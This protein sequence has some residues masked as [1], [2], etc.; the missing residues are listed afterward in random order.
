M[1]I[2]GQGLSGTWLSYWL[3]QAGISFLVVDDGAPTAA[4]RICSGVI[5]PVTGRRM[6][7]TWLASELLPFAT[8]AYTAIGAFLQVGKPL[9]SGSEILDFFSAPDRRL[10][11]AEKAAAGNEYLHWP[12]DQNQWV[13]H[14]NYALGFGTISPAYLVNVQALLLAWRDWLSHKGL[15]IAAGFHED[16]LVMQE[17]GVEWHDVKARFA[18]LATGK[19]EALGKRFG[20]LPFACN[21]GEALIIEAM[22][23][24]QTHI[25]KM[26]QTLVPWGGQKFWAGSSYENDFEHAGPT[27]AFRHRTE[28]WLRS[29]VRT[30]F[31]VVDHLAAIRPATV[32]R[33]PFAGFHPLH[34]SLAIIN[35]MGTKGVSLAP[36]V[37]QHL[38]KHIVAKHPLPPEIDV[39]RFRRI[40]SAKP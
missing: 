26:G 15:L 31:S 19:T 20:L 18:V 4:S 37:A 2:V 1:L 12:V 11:F 40:L 10:A 8:R 33:R 5:N 16:D 3:Q 23:L 14:F 27:D 24:P 29:V 6:S 21:K 36:W 32:E 34:P 35:G 30:E 7:T 38:A 9:I 17:H 25:F 39:Q 28:A 22:G 13:K